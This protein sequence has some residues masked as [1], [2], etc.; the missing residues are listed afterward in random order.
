MDVA[1][2]TYLDLD[3]IDRSLVELREKIQERRQDIVEREQRLHGSKQSLEETRAHIRELQK[4]VD[5]RNVELQQ[6]E[7]AVRKMLVQQQQLKTNEEY[8]AMQKQIDGRRAGVGG[9]EDLI[10]EAMEVLEEGRKA[11]PVE[12]E[13]VARST[14]ELEKVR[15]AASAEIEKLEAEIG[16]LEKQWEAAAAG[17]DP[18]ARRLYEQQRNRHRGKAM[19]AVNDVGISDCC[20]I[21]LVSQHLNEVMSGR[22]VQCPSC[23][24]LL[25][26]PH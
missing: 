5:Q 22:V 25:Y 20:H 9:V 1:L 10:L 24:R 18:D 17:L 16:A 8:A 6:A 26:F 11:I 2:K 13:R 19:A 21:A 15:A 7:D 14:E 4:R 12:E 23:S 3:A